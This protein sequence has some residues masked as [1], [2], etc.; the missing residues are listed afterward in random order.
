MAVYLTATEFRNLTNL[1]STEYSDTQLNQLI[2]AAT[3]EIDLVTGRT[4][5]GVATATNEYYDGDGTTELQL[6]QVDIGAVSAIS[7]D[8]DLNGTYTSITPSY[9]L[10]YASEGKLILATVRYSAIEATEFTKGN[11]TVKVTYT[12]GNS[13]AT[14]VV[15]NLCA[16]M[17]LQEL[18]PEAQL[19]ETIEKRIGLLRANSIKVI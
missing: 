11:K 3:A 16:L 5:Q 12:Y 14:D 10:V 1:Q 8:E 15:K 17:V 9:V 6:K 4:W 19:K 2:S 13:A 18:R 7:V